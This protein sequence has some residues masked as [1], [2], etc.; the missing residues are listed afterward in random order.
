MGSKVSIELRKSLKILTIYI[1]KHLT[2]FCNNLFSI[3]FC[4]AG[5]NNVSLRVSGIQKSLIILDS[6]S[7]SACRN[8]KM[9]S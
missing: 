9:V 2:F 1:C 3:T 5:L 8:D 6:V 4:H 7:R